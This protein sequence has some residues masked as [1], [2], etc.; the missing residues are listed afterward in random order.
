MAEDKSPANSVAAM[1]MVVT[2]VNVNKR[3]SRS[4]D[5]ARQYRYV[6]I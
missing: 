5:E 1:P 3:E 2:R 6:T 4:G